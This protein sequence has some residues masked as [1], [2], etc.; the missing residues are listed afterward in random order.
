MVVHL[1]LLG[2]VLGATGQDTRE[3]QICPRHCCACSH[4]SACASAAFLVG[5]WTIFQL[6]HINI[7][8]FLSTMRPKIPL[9]MQL[10]LH[11]FP[12]CSRNTVIGL[13]CFLQRQSS[14]SASS[15]PYPAPDHTHEPPVLMG[16][17]CG[18]R[19]PKAALSLSSQAG[20]CAAG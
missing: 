16:L 17:L 8:S 15:Q 11:L 2:W 4:A 9:S 1:F 19:L 5:C 18:Y 7:S 12:S 10:C 6:S 14:L 3:K 13:F 20:S